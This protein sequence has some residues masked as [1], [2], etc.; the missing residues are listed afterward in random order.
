VSG[1]SLRSLCLLVLDVPRVRAA[2]CFDCAVVTDSPSTATVHCSSPGRCDHK[3]LCSLHRLAHEQA[4]HTVTPV[5]GDAAVA[6]AVS[7]HHGI[8]GV[9]ATLF[10]VTC[11]Q[12]V[13]SLCTV[14]PHSMTGG[15]KVLSIADAAAALHPAL[16]ADVGVCASSLG[17]HRALLARLRSLVESALER[18]DAGREAIIAHYD[19]LVAGLVAGREAD[20]AAYDRTCDALASSAR[21]QELRVAGTANEIQLLVDVGTAA[22]GSADPLDV[23]QCVASVAATTRVA[24]RREYPVTE[25]GV[26]F[27]P[28]PVADVRLTVDGSP[29]AAG[30]IVTSDVDMV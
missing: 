19:R 14:A 7:V 18:Q 30:R 17:S 8:P 29:V 23:I 6:C 3:P 13:C 5:S 9:E 26:E 21:E 10:C 2:L 20:L 22:L 11:R 28:V 1:A 15:H 4:K 27:V 12:I 25:C 24:V 16:A